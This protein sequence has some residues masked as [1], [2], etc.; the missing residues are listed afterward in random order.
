VAFSLGLDGRRFTGAERIDDTSGTTTLTEDRLTCSLVPVPRVVISGGGPIA[1]AL[2]QA[3][4]V[5]GWR[6]SVIPDV[7]GAAGV[8]ATLSSLDAVVVMGHDVESSGRALQAAIA[9]AAGYIASIGSVDMQELRRQWMSFRGVDWDER[10]HGPAGLP[11]GASNPGEIA[12]SIVAEA[13]AAFR[14]EDE[15]PGG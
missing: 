6:P 9:S 10:V 13:V 5:I 1:E 11:I 12:V 15:R 14:L 3:F 4:D 2:S 7:G 8:M